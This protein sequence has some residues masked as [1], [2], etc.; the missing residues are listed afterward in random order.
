MSSTISLNHCFHL[1]WLNVT[2]ETVVEVLVTMSMS[3][4]SN[5]LS[6]SSRPISKCCY[7]SKNRKLQ[8][9][10]LSCDKAYNLLDLSMC[11]AKRRLSDEAA[12]KLVMRIFNRATHLYDMN[13]RSRVNVA[14]LLNLIPH[15]DHAHSLP[16]MAIQSY[17]LGENQTIGDCSIWYWGIMG[18]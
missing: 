5:T 12:A 8:L 15:S 17:R 13:T 16:Y 14:T 11:R 7:F 1:D 10:T 6:C 4:L 9:P 2:I 18:Y 3:K